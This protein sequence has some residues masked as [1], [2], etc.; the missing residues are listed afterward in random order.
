ML[1]F[2]YNFFMSTPEGPDTLSVCVCLCVE[3]FMSG[4]IALLYDCQSFGTNDHHNKIT[5]Y[6]QK[7]HAG[8]TEVKVT[9]D[10]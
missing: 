9:V 5:C 6:K 8:D 4:L 7:I 2:S 1:G 10:S 3:I